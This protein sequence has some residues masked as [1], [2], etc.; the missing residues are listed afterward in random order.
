VYNEATAEVQVPLRDTRSAPDELVELLTTI[1]PPTE[2]D[3]A[4]GV[5]P[6]RQIPQG[7]A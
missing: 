2:A 4:P 3:P 1:L 5:T 6:V 7:A